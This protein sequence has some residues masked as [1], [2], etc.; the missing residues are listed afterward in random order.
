VGFARQRPA[1]KA[2]GKKG[3]AARAKNMMPERRAEIAKKAARSRW[4]SSYLPISGT[5]CWTYGGCAARRKAAIF[6]P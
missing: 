1:A 2:L 5:I 4:A 3:G 6:V